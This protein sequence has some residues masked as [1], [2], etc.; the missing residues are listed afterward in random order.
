[1]PGN[2]LG[3]LSGCKTVLCEVGTITNE[4]TQARRLRNL[5]KITQLVEGT[6]RM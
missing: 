1:M 6:A 4:E 3:V 5:L 2:V